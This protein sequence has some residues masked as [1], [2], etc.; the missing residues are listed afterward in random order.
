VEVL[1][2]VVIVSMVAVGAIGGMT[3]MNR[4][5]MT[6]RLLTLASNV[7]RDQVD[8]L[9]TVG[10]FNPQ[11]NR[12]PAELA[13]GT[14]TTVPAGYSA[15]CAPK[16]PLYVCGDMPVVLG[17][18]TT[19]VADSGSQGTYTAVV[20]VEFQYGNQTLAVTRDMR[21]TSDE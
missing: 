18:M 8:R 6:N 5:A 1:V 4:I 2:S 3:V 19:S 12:V 14:R 17:T 10:P 7:A 11:S 13:L 20:R 9:Q 21:R 16:F 15:C